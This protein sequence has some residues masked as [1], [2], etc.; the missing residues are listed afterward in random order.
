MDKII[1]NRDRRT[2]L[3]DQSPFHSLRPHGFLSLHRRTL[4][5]WYGILR[6]KNTSKRNL[7]Y[8]WHTFLLFSF[9]DVWIKQPILATCYLKQQSRQYMIDIVVYMYVNTFFHLL[10]KK[11]N[12]MQLIWLIFRKSLRVLLTTARA[13]ML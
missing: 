4:V 7:T 13:V 3:S 1:K 10:Y 5:P 12:R 8:L 6:E 9:I 2:Y 11:F